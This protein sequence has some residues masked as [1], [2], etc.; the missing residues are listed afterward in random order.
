MSERELDEGLD[1]IDDRFHLVRCRGGLVG[2]AAGSPAFA[3]MVWGDL[4]TAM[5]SD[6]TPVS[7]RFAPTCPCLPPCRYED[8]ALPAVDWVL[9]VAR[10][11]VYRYGIRGLVIDVRVAATSLKCSTM[12]F[13]A[14][15]TV[16]HAVCF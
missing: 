7:M 13:L 4:A 3:G 5:F 1:W 12:C 15:G 6:C 10:A 2:A 11:A 8:D 14:I 16:Q 9:D